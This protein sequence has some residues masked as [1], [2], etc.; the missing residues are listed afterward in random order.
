MNSTETLTKQVGTMVTESV[1]TQI[2]QIAEDR[3]WSIAKTSR[4]LITEALDARA[5]NTTEQAA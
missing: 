2:A 3:Q 1:Y 5:T 4:V